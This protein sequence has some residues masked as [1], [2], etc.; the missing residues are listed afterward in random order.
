MIVKLIIIKIKEKIIQKLNQVNPPWKGWL[1][2][3]M[4]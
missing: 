2:H 4:I 3:M 1:K